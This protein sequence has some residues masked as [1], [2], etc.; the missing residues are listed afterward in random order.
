MSTT[1]FFGSLKTI[2]T[3]LYLHIFIFQEQYIFLHKMV[4]ELI[5][6]N[7]EIPEED[8][9]VVY[10]ESSRYQN[11][12]PRTTVPLSHIEQFIF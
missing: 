6:R 9:D 10:Q 4:E 1:V 5:K 8:E 12:K 2:Y 3:I 11:L 7:F